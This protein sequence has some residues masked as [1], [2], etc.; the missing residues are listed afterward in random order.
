MVKNKVSLVEGD[1]RW[2]FSKDNQN[3]YFWKEVPIAN[4]LTNY[5]RKI[6][7]IRRYLN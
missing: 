1:F 6:P 5:L 2:I 7:L 4:K 3:N